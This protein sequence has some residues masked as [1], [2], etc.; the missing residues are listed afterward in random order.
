MYLWMLNEEIISCWIV[1]YKRG[2][3]HFHRT[4]SL[5][6]KYEVIIRLKLGSGFL[7]RIMLI[8]NTEYYKFFFLWS[9]STYEWLFSFSFK[10]YFLSQL[11]MFSWIFKWNFEI[12]PPF[13]N[14]PFI[15]TIIIDN[16]C[17]GRYIFDKFVGKYL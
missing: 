16:V 10:K 7:S 5:T 13:E 4:N 15:H 9:Y 12:F 1:F 2:K 14:S 11:W 17:T 3:D 8:Y 6:T